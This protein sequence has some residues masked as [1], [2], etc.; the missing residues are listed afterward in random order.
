MR[1]VFYRVQLEEQNKLLLRIAEALERLSPALPAH[2]PPARLSDLSDLR[3]VNYAEQRLLE[4]LKKV[5]AEMWKVDPNSPAFDNALKA[6]EEEI[7]MGNES[8]RAGSGQEA[9][10]EL[11]WNRI[12]RQ[13]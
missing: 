9:V 4:E 1:I 2:E 8:M 11:P 10:D 6:F 7:R 13:G 5:F 12:G 3:T